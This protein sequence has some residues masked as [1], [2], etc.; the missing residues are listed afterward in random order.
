[1]ALVPQDSQ[2]RDRMDRNRDRE[3]DRD[4]ERERDRDR[5]RNR[6]GDRDRD[7]DRDRTRGR[8]RDRDKDIRRPSRRSSPE[9]GDYN[10][11]SSTPQP[12]PHADEHRASMY[13]ARKGGH[14]TGGTPSW[15][16][17]ERCVVTL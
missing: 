16:Y 10:K 11:R 4:R 12:L 13:P 1:M 15:Q 6:H 17:L 2:F 9:Y 3:R 14:Y 8:D 5:D 7:R